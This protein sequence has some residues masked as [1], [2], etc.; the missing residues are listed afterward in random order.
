MGTHPIFESDFDCLTD[1]KAEPLIMNKAAETEATQARNEE[2]KKIVLV[3]DD[4]DEDEE[5]ELVDPMEA[6]REQC[7]KDAHSLAL[8][9]EL[10]KCT[11]RVESRT[12]T[13]ETCT[14]ELFDFIGHRDHCV[15][16]HLFNHLK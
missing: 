16:H 1:W 6:L 5:E 12:M 4:D 10:A 13:E 14:Q 15:A 8:L 11:E 3:A 9:D 7:S 2:E